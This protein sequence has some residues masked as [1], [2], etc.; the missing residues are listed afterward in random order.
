M[1]PYPF[2]LQTLDQFPLFQ[3]AA[4]TP[5]SSGSL[6]IQPTLTNSIVSSKGQPSPPHDP[7]NPQPRKPPQSSPK[8]VLARS[9]A[10][11]SG[12]GPSCRTSR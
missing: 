1:N 6:P 4:A 10:P 7:P 11:R 9:P 12:R 3:C 8:Q 2:F 5:F